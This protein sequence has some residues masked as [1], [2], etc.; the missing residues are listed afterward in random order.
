MS[1]DYVGDSSSNLTADILSS[2]SQL[3]AVAIQSSQSQPL[4]TPTF[5]RPVTTS[6]LPLTHTSGST[7]LVLAALL[8]VGYLA[9]KKL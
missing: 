8:G 7:W 5:A 4:S 9:F 3:G 6:V 1:A 2:V